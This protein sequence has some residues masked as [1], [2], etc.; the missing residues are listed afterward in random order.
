MG[1]GLIQAV[2]PLRC[3]GR[4][5]DSL[6]AGA[7]RSSLHCLGERTTIHRLWSLDEVLWGLFG[8]KPKL[9]RWKF[10]Y[11]LSTVLLSIGAAASTAETDRGRSIVSGSA[12]SR[13]NQ[14]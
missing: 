3:Y 12:V 1:I 9:G 6:L 5:T 10:G 2:V 4:D 7:F 8:T 14:L 11:S 13:R